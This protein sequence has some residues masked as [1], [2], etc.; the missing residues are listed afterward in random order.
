VGDFKK[1][2][3]KKVFWKKTNDQCLTREI[4]RNSFTAQ[5]CERHIKNRSKKINL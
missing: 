5:D 1:I 3:Y 2:H 4:Q